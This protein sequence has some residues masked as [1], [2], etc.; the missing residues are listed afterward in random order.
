MYV[1][2][3]MYLFRTDGDGYYYTRNNTDDTWT[4]YRHNNV[5]DGYGFWNVNTAPGSGYFVYFVA[6]GIV[7]QYAMTGEI[8][9]KKIR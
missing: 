6:Y 9:Q 8:L 3:V 7:L 2:Y 5:N 4:R 1:L